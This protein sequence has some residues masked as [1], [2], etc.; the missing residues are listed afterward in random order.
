MDKITRQ[1][2]AAIWDKLGSMDKKISDFIDMV[3]NA[4]TEGITENS[5]GILDI[6]EL[7]DENSS[8]IIDLADMVNELDERVTALEEK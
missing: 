2:I 5:T 6:A 3:H 8:S 4:S 1:E 7:S